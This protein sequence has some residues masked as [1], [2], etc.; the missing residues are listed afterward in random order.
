MNEAELITQLELK[1]EILEEKNRAL[2]GT[3]K[4]LQKKLIKA[5]AIPKEVMAKMYSDSL[6]A[7]T[8]EELMCK[9]QSNDPDESA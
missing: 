6:C 5:I 3:I 4:D 7:T 9:P 8:Y 1:V 2:L